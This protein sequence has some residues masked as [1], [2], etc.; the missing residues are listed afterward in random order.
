VSEAE[1]RKH[2]EASGA[3]ADELRKLPPDLPVPQDDGRAVHLVGSSIPQVEL[4]GS[5]GATVDLSSVS[6]WLVLY[7]YPKMA[8]AL[9][10]VPQGW[11]DIPGARGCTVQSLRYND[12]LAEFDDLGV[13]LYGISTE[14]PEE[15]RDAV[16]RL[17]LKQALLSD[18]DET[19]AR[20]LLLPTFEVEQKRYLQRL[21]L[22]IYDGVIARVWYPV[23]P[24]GQDSSEVRAWVAGRSPKGGST[25]S[26]GDQ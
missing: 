7:C 21:T 9:S 3:S 26:V 15:Q 13:A 20:A 24:P 4:V 6:G 18:V 11:V 16:R 17:G 14:S 5:G 8:K 22:C 23:F 2:G 12:E 10:E 1:K 25:K 19:L